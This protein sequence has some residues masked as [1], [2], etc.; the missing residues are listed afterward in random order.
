MGI[1]FIGKR[2]FNEFLG[3]YFQLTKG[4]FVDYDTK[5]IVGTHIGKEA[6]T[7]KYTKSMTDALVTFLIFQS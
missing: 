5:Q 3:N 2:D 4:N 7:S 1:C 6:F